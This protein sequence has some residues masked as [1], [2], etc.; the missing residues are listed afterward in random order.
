MDGISRGTA[1]ERNGREPL[2][3]QIKV[4]TK[5]FFLSGQ[6]KR[7]FSAF[8][9]YFSSE[10]NQDLKTSPEQFKKTTFISSTKK[11]KKKSQIY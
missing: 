5:D 7:H 3:G 10:G 8:F 11:A 6:K 9:L 4:R 2:I 1:G